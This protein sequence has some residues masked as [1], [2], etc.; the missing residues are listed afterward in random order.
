MKL[1][2][3]TFDLNVGKSGDELMRRGALFSI[4]ELFHWW[5]L[6]ELYP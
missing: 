4:Y 6:R 1:H 3:F 2:V 5:K